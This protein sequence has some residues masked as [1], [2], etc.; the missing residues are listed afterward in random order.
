MTRRCFL[1]ATAS[2]AVGSVCAASPLN[3][4]TSDASQDSF[5]RKVIQLEARL[6]A[7][8]GAVV[9]S[10]QI[11]L[12]WAHRA[13]ERFPMC[14]TFKLLASGALLARVDRGQERLDHVVRFE[15]ADV[16]DYSPI[17]QSQA[18][19]NGMTLAQL[20][21]AAL[22]HSDNTAGNLILEH[23]G[24]PVGVTEFA[25]TLGDTMTRLDRWETELNEATPG[26]PRDT[27]TPDAMS[28]CVDALLFGEAL[29]ASSQQRLSDWLIANKTGDAKL[30]AGMP[31]S[32]RIGDKTG[33][34]NHGTMNDVAVI[35]PPGREPLIVSI[36]MTETAASF[37]DRNAAFA[38]LGRTLCELV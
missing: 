19:G 13:D 4:N 30:R 34:G 28:H 3:G 33:G 17:T 6:G 16:V 20:C 35:W 24:G 2:L 9:R 5:I 15:L 23:V 29:S 7:R 27:T 22:T 18:D 8:I 36:Y 14:S 12:H 37:D 31:A 26:D 1:S 21:E 25:R 32:W 38:E 10:P 11:N